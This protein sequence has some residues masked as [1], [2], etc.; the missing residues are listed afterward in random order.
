MDDS[1]RVA[2]LIRD[3]LAR[4][5]LSR[6]EFAH[7][8]RLGKSTV[9]KLLIGL[10]SDRTLAIV[11]AGTGLALRT[12]APPPAPAS[13]GPSIAVLPF[14][15]MSGD[16]AQEELGDGIAEDILTALARLRWLL[17]IARNS[18]F[19]YKGR[20]T[21]VRVIGRELGV[22]YVLEGSVRTAGGRIRATAQ[23]VHAESGKHI[24]AERYDRD[25]GDLFAV[26]DEITGSVVAAI[27]PRLYE[28]EG[29]RAAARPPE[30]IDAWGLVI[31]ALN[32]IS[33]VS[34]KNYAEAQALLRRAIEIEPDYAR[35]HALLAWAIWWETLCYGWPDP[36]EGYARAARVAEEATALDPAEPWARMVLG[37]CLSNRGEHA[38]ALTELRMAVDLS[39]NSP[40]GRMAH[41]WALLRAGEAPL[42]VEE[43]ARA[44][45]MSPTDSFSG[46][47]AS[48]H[49]LALL[50]DRR[51][52][53]ALPHLRAAVAAF[54]EYPGHYHTL[55]SCCGHLGL[56]EEAR[57]FMAIRARIGPPLHLGVIRTVL[58]RF[59]HCD[60]FVEGLAKAGVPE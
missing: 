54:G 51:F 20:A 30:S 42:A 45:R 4:E 57:H 8:T 21:D 2:G 10:F 23:L 55:I 22:R 40:L 25:L 49:G 50:A 18:S 14:T 19:A 39:P 38:R 24:W 12:E 43:T 47:Y 48:V 3:Y 11:E 33:R 37:L 32:L 28:E 56:L 59:A 1:K 16:P 27:E 5:R 13:D 31:R 15:N 29:F 34:R 44:L 35:A 7:R 36:S 9:D 41:G 53:E 60:L 26:Q 46:H 17:V 52:A 58:G 6:E